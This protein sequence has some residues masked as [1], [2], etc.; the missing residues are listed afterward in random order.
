MQPST[1]DFGWESKQ[2]DKALGFLGPSL[3][4]GGFSLEVANTSPQ[5]M[6]TRDPGGYAT[7]FGPDS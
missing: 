7:L 1:L 2:E 5:A 4:A 6:H 3:G